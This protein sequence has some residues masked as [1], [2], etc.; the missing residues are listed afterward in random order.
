MTR[1]AV[2]QENRAPELPFPLNVRLAAAA[3]KLIFLHKGEVKSDASQIAEWNRGAYLAESLSHCGS[4]HT[5]RNVFG[6]EKQ[7]EQY[8]G[9]EAE[10][11][12]APA[13]T[14][15]S[16]A[17]APWTVDQIYA[18][19]RTGFAG[20]HGAAVGPMVPVVNDLKQA[21]E[22]DVRALAYYV[23]SLTGR[24]NN[25]QLEQ[26]AKN[27]R[28][29]AQ[30]RDVNVSRHGSPGTTGSNAGKERVTNESASP[31]GSDIFAG[32]CASC[33]HSGGE[34]PVSRPIELGLSTSVNAPDPTNL[35]RIVLDGIH[36]APGERGML[37]PDFS[38]ALTDAQIVAVVNYA[39]RQFSTQPPWLSIANTLSMVRQTKK[40]QR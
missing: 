12:H 22:S 40:V 26:K 9:G 37:M 35:I 25:A 18:Y 36:P 17:P 39:R 11:W 7:S 10:G 2:T 28:D 34:L 8:A 19:L 14:A 23:T 29:F 15:A 24:E 5:P 30:S 4:C 32:A 33:H 13:L 16:P 27:A 6:A 1:D 20:D 38:G 31:S 21:P 3:W